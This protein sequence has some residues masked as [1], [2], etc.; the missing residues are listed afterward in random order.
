MPAELSRNRK[1]ELLEN[2]LHM[3][4][5]IDAGIEVSQDTSF[6]PGIYLQ[7]SI[8]LGLSDHNL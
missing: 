7:A 3:S 8:E 1:K 5:K 4:E 6:A 2:L